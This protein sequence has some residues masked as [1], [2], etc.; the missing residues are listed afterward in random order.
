MEYKI[1]WLQLL[2][3]IVKWSNI[4]YWERKGF[5]SHTGAGGAASKQ[6]A[7]VVAAKPIAKRLQ[8]ATRQ[9]RCHTLQPCCDKQLDSTYLGTEGCIMWGVWETG[10]T[11]IRIRD[12]STMRLANSWKRKQMII[13]DCLLRANIQQN[14]VNIF[15][16]LQ[17]IKRIDGRPKKT[18]KKEYERRVI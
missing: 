11:P 18:A 1:V 5:A 2:N 15:K 10:Q 7:V 8:C 13:R 14:Y 12:R 3:E 9:L 6:N 16:Y 4:W 17:I